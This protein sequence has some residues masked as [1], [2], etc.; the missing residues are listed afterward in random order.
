MERDERDGEIAVTEREFR[1]CDSCGERR[2]VAENTEV[3]AFDED[4]GEEEVSAFA[5][6]DEF[7]TEED[8]DAAI[9]EGTIDTST[10]SSDET[11]V[12]TDPEGMFRDEDDEDNEADEGGEKE[13]DDVKERVREATGTE[14]TR[15]EN[16]ETQEADAD[17]A[18]PDCGFSSSDGSLRAG[19]ICPEC[20][21]YI[22]EA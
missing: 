11:E 3:R 1:V 9:I 12:E 13:E 15:T 16:E 18:C 6:S 2:V 17:Y 7:E 14:V 8:E 4:I 21:G 19:D 22:E 20:G 5:P 10:P